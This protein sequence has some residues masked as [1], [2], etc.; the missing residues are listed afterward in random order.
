MNPHL[1]LLPRVLVDERTAI[2][3]IPLD[4]RRQRHGPM[5]LTLI[6]IGCVHNLLNTHIK[7]LVLVSTNLDAELAGYSS[8]S[9]CRLPLGCHFFYLYLGHLSVNLKN[10]TRANCLRS[11]EHTSELQ[12][13]VNLV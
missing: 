7:D 10:H 5:D 3:R 2:N 13:H 9:L 4:L 8:F 1:K 12:S 6:T 11:E